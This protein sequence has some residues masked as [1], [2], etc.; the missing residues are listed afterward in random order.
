RGAGREERARPPAHAHPRA[1]GAMNVAR[2]RG[3]IFGATGTL[4]RALAE[5]LPRHGIDVVGPI[6][7]RAGCDIGDRAAVERVVAELRPDVVFNA[8]AFTDVDGAEDQAE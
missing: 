2:L 4:G 6:A 8:A 5:R 7:G 3:V 1:G